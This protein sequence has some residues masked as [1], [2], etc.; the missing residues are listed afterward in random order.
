MDA[1]GRMTN[2]SPNEGATAESNFTGSRVRILLIGAYLPHSAGS[3]SVA[4]AMAERLQLRGFDLRLTSRLRSRFL[5][6]MDLL[7]TTWRSRNLYD[8]AHVDVYSGAAFR[9]A[10]WAVGLIRAGGKPFVLTLRGGNLPM[11][12]QRHPRRVARLLAAATAVTAPSAYLADAMRTIRSDIRIIPNPI[13]LDAYS[14]SERV[15]PRPRL[16]WLRAFHRIYD[17]TL[18]VRVLAKVADH[19]A[20]AHLTMIGADKD[21]SLANVRSEAKRLGVLHLIDFTGG[22]PKAKVPELLAASDI[23]LNTTTIDNAPVSL[24]EAMATGLIVIST[25]VGGVPYLIDDEREGLLV[26]SGDAD[27]MANAVRR[28]LNEPGLAGRLSRG[29]RSRAQASGWNAVLPRWEALFQEVARRGPSQ[30]A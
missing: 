17:P 27:A 1:S 10:E 16:V 24:L 25:S 4:E 19:E 21:G 2:R 26:P 20:S 3:R 13:A 8:V 9:W 30:N 5:R 28:A 14:C 6:V 15:A 23:F 18:A 22:V 7:V 29:A 12:A 11:F